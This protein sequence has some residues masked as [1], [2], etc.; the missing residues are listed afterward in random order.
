VLVGTQDELD[1]AAAALAQLPLPQLRRLYVEPRDPWP[2]PGSLENV[3]GELRR[4]P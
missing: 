3:D 1:V 2:E 4:A